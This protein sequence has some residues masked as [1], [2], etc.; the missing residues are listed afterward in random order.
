[1]GFVSPLVIHAAVAATL[2]KGFGDKR[3]PEFQ[4]ESVV[5][6]I[7]FGGA[8]GQEQIPFDEFRTACPVLVDA[9]L[10]S[11]EKDD[12]G[13]GRLR[14]EGWA[15]PFEGTCPLEKILEFVLVDLDDL[16]RPF[17]PAF[18]WQAA[19]V[20]RH[21]EDIFVQRGHLDPTS[22]LE[23]LTLQF[24]W[25]FGSG[26]PRSAES[27]QGKD[28]QDR[29]AKTKGAEHLS[30]F[31]SLRKNEADGKASMVTSSGMSTRMI[32]GMSMSQTTH[33]I[34][35]FWAEKTGDIR[36]FPTTR[37]RDDSSRV[38]SFCGKDST[39]AC[40]CVRPQGS[41]SACTP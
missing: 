23:V 41:C 28:R 12:R 30:R 5:T 36:S 13:T 35:H 33:S 7:V 20:G 10:G 37:V 25:L 38:A 8:T 19:L 40:P 6:E 4:V 18:A 1:M 21:A 26:P 34:I 24:D 15:C 2:S 14:T 29:S 39:A 31:E 16:D 9:R 27:S 3:G 11:V 17:V 32:T 22:V